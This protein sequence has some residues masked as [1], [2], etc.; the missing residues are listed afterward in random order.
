MPDDDKCEAMLSAF[1]QFNNSIK[2]ECSP[3]YA[4]S[5]QQIEAKIAAADAVVATSVTPQQSLAEMGGMDDLPRLKKALG[6]LNKNKKAQDEKLQQLLS[7]AHLHKKHITFVSL[8]M[9]YE[10]T[11]YKQYADSVVAT[12]SYNQ[13]LDPQTQKMTGPT[14]IS[15][16]KLLLG[17]LA[18]TGMP[19]VTI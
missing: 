7:F 11:K 10:T 16:A 4:L 9:P 3:Y 19:P 14:Y 8:R 18:A 13:Y 2:V 12:Y 1:G 17:K 5:Q 15:L 6:N